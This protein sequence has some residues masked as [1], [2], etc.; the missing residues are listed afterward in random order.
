MIEFFSEFIE[1]GEIWTWAA[2]AGA[3]I[4]VI[5][6]G[7]PLL[8]RA[9]QRERVKAVV[10]ERRRNLAATQRQEMEANA[11][12]IRRNASQSLA[13]LFQIE[14]YA[15]L[16]SAREK[17]AAAGYRSPRA[18]LIY[19]TARLAAPAI[20]AV[21]AFIY[22][23]GFDISNTERMGIIVA[24]A[25]FGFFLP[26]LFVINAAQKRKDEV[27]NNFPDALDL[28]LVCVE[29]GLSV[30]AA[31]D[32]V[33]H[34]IEEQSTVLGEE[35]GLLSAELALLGDRSGAF[36]NFATRIS[37]PSA[38]TFANTL[39]QAEKYGTSLG[40]ALRTLAGDLR[41]QRMSKAERIAA[42]LPAKLTVPMILFFLP[43]LFVTILGPAII[44]VMQTF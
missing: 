39:I 43:G 42:A 35:L 7:L 10:V 31:I 20:M 15:G 17:L 23:T 37:E 27:A 28:M 6:A 2:A 9:D 38:R 25:V 16:A 18:A 4:S 13:E 14:R 34:E 19:M 26:L 36:K 11:A 3:M 22:T 12:L 32:R 33:A 41:D 30:E 40:R 8:D 44:K 24:T 1:S 21:L 29:G 5:Y